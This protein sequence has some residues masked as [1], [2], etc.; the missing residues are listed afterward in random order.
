MSKIHPKRLG[1]IAQKE[2]R[3]FTGEKCKRGH[4]SER[5]TANARCVMCNAMNGLKYETKN[6]DKVNALKRKYYAKDKQKQRDRVKKWRKSNPEKVYLQYK[7]WSKK[8]PSIKKEIFL[9]W[10]DK[11]KAVVIANNRARDLL[12]KLRVPSWANLKDIQKIYRLRD[13][14]NKWSCIEWHVDHIIP[15]KGETV[16]GLHVANNLRVIPASQNLQKKNRFD[17]WLLDIL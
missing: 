9:R 10:R 14:W 5:Y 13:K 7:N 1:A 11:N 6:R 12:K 8:N 15:L 4:C 17:E 3:Y 16:C 2:S